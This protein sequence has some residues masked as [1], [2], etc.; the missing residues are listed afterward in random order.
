MILDVFK[1]L[2]LR[3]F[4]CAL[5]I[6]L[7]ACNSSTVEEENTQVPPTPDPAKLQNQDN[8]TSTDTKVAKNNTSS[9]VSNA[10]NSVSFPQDFCGDKIPTAS[11]TDYP[12][13]LY[14]IVSDVVTGLSYFEYLQTIQ[15]E[16]CNNVFVYQERSQGLRGNR[17]DQSALEIRYYIAFFLDKRNAINFQKNLEE[18]AEEKQIKNVRLGEPIQLNSFQEFINIDRDFRFHASL[19]HNS[20]N[21][22]TTNGDEALLSENQVTLLREISDRFRIILPTYIPSGFDLADIQV[23]KK[24]DSAY[25]L[26]SYGLL[27]KNTDDL[28]I[29]RFMSNSSKSE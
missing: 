3:P 11:S 8:E 29:S 15:S 2:K 20:N 19:G 12:L 16:I 13:T 1:G 9:E 4:L 25:G 23:K 17:D 18:I 21:P 10:L 28:A 27:Y 26:T 5:T 24:L 7:S 14:P 6:A 22:K